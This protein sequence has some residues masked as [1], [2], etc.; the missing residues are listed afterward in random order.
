MPRSGP[1][2]VSVEDAREEEEVFSAA[3][4]RGIGKEK[5]TH[6]GIIA[7][8]GGRALLSDT[9]CSLAACQV[10]ALYK[11]VYRIELMMI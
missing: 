2:W 6:I 3:A 1:A 9:Y 11:V 5:E 8:I 4:R 10:Y 7:R